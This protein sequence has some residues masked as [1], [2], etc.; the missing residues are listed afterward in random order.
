MTEDFLFQRRFQNWMFRLETL[1]EMSYQQT[2]YAVMKQFF[3]DFTE[4]E[5]KTVSIRHMIQQI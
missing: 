5:L 4:E 2:A 3:T 1:K